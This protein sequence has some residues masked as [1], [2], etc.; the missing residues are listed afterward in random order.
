[1]FMVDTDRIILKEA[2]KFPMNGRLIHEIA[3]FL[4]A[5]TDEDTEPV[6]VRPTG[7]VTGGRQ[8]W[9]L[10]E[11]RHRYF[12]HVIANRKSLPAELDTGV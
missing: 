2:G 11:G 7:L 5:N 6:L 1:M 8:I 12:A 3:T 10:M 9:R 4:K